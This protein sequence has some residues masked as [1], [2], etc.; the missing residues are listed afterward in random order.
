MGSQ[1]ALLIPT[2]MATTRGTATCDDTSPF[3]PVVNSV[4]VPLIRT[5]T[6]PSTASP[7]NNRKRLSL[8]NSE[9]ASSVD[10][11]SS[12]GVCDMSAHGTDEEGSLRGGHHDPKGHHHKDRK[13][14]HRSHSRD[15][16]GTQR[17]HQ[18]DHSHLR[19]SKSLE[20]GSGPKDSDSNKG[21]VK[22]A[23]EEKKLNFFARSFS[24]STERNRS[25]SAENA[26]TVPLRRGTVKDK[27]NSEPRRRSLI[28][29]ITHR[30]NNEEKGDPRRR[31]LIETKTLFADAKKSLESA[32]SAEGKLESVS[33]G[34]HDNSPDKPTAGSNPKKREATEVI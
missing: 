2:T 22:T 20:T 7:A 24:L 8:V 10:S 26:M 16:F 9:T 1:P 29:R 34:I 30:S 12:S 27:T 15:Y 5:Y 19:E 33:S 17:G 11:S 14:H 28:E 25:R 21:K 31:S 6:A 4:H 13:S 3:H 23:E 32:N 18:K